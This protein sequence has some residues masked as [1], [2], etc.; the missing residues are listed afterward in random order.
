[1]A[2]KILKN[3]KKDPATKN[4]KDV[5][6]ASDI[7]IRIGP[8]GLLQS[9]NENIGDALHSLH[10]YKDINMA[11]AIYR[12]GKYL[13]R[14]FD[15]IRILFNAKDTDLALSHP[16][17][18]NTFSFNVL[19]EIAVTSVK[20]KGKKKQRFFFFHFYFFFFLFTAIETSL[21]GGVKLQGVPEAILNFPVGNK[22]FFNSIGNP[23]FLEKL[24]KSIVIFGAQVVNRFMVEIR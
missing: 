1:M 2:K 12:S 8:H 5:S 22:P 20:A 15:S 7:Y 6:A 24:E 10:F 19:N 21:P 23:N 3:L 11:Y 9:A 17:D 16:G 18:Q 13:Q 14:F 4:N